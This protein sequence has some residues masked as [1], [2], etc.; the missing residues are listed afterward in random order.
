[1]KT[2][3]ITD[4]GALEDFCTLASSSPFLAV[5]TEFARVTTYWPKLCLVQIATEDTIAL[6]D[7]LAIKSLAPLQ[8]LLY[9]PAILKIF[10]A[11]RQDLEIFFHLWGEV[12]FPI[13]DTQVLAS[14]CGYGENIAYEKLVQAIMHKAVAKDVS[15]TEWEKRP[16]TTKHLDYA[17]ADVEYLFGLYTHLTEQAGP[18][19]K[20]IQEEI[21][22]LLAPATYMHSPSEGWQRIKVGNFSSDPQFWQNLQGIAAWREEMAQQRNMTRSRILKDEI[23]IDLARKN[24]LTVRDIRAILPSE[25]SAEATIIKETIERYQPFCPPRNNGRPKNLPQAD[26]LKILLKQVAE[27]LKIVPK[28][29]STQQNLEEFAQS[30]QENSLLKGWRREVFGNNALNI[31][32]GEKAIG[33]KNGKIYLQ[34]SC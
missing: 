12:P 18:K 24:P 3:L 11:A 5:D 23:I 15:Y 6:I 31:L 14:V 34:P 33:Y 26:L 1:M 13:A 7:P 8:G 9:N 28:L 29:I 30:P 27:D 19:I 22:T 17:A 25:V 20:W 4:T 2:L 10:H 32:Q 16:L 21:D